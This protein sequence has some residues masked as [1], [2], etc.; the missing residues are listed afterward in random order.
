M[1]TII[2]KM[3]ALLKAGLTEEQALK[4]M[5]MQSPQENVNTTRSLSNQM[6]DLSKQ[7]AGLKKM[8][9]NEPRESVSIAVPYGKL[10]GG[11]IKISINGQGLALPCDGK[12]YEVPKSFKEAIIERLKNLDMIDSQKGPELGLDNISDAMKVHG[13]AEGDVTIATHSFK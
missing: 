10:T 2:E 3:S 13:L 8:F 1:A 11:F 9:N 4:A 7:L 5:S 6:P 12:T